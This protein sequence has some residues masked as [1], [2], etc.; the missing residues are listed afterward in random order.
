MISV[1]GVVGVMLGGSLAR[2]DADEASDVDLGVFYRGTDPPSI[3]A[4][5]SLAR[6]L[7]SA[8]AATLSDFG[9]WGPWI[10]GGAWLSVEGQRVDWIY[11]DLE[12]VASIVKDCQSGR[13]VSDYQ[14]G[15]PHGFHSFIYFGEV[16]IGRIIEDPSGA[17]GRLKAATTPFPSPLRGAIEER[18][19]WEARFS[20]QTAAKAADRGDAVYVVGCMFRAIACLVQVLFAL[21][22]QPFTNEKGAVRAVD[23]LEHRPDRFAERVQAALSSVTEGPKEL[24]AALAVLHQVAA[25]TDGL[26]RSA[27]RSSAQWGR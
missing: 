9:G 18:F 25:E 26:T 14:P 2:G 12:R 27:G 13:F 10:D 6:E 1:P 16:A 15:H 20:L 7:D 23:G 4:L 24:K 21:N 22:E 17:L 8:S 3:E 5:R 19:G 11:R